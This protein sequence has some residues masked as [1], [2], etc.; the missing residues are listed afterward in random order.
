MILLKPGGRRG[1][2][3]TGCDQAIYIS[4]ENGI[5]QHALDLVA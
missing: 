2:L 4:P 5:G 3:P 1:R